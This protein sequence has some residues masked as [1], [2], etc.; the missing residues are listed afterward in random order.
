MSKA[1]MYGINRTYVPNTQADRQWR[2]KAWSRQ[3]ANVQRENSKVKA[4]ADSFEKEMKRMLEMTR[5]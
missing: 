1:V 3:Q 4:E 5:R 2:H